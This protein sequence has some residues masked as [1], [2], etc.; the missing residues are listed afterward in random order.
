M[1]RQTLTRLISWLLSLTILGAGLVGFSYK[2]EDREIKIGVLQYVEHNALD[3]A[4]QG[5]V[6][7]LNDSPYGEQI[8]WDIK[9][10]SGDQANL[11]SITNVL[12]REN[13]YLYA[14]ATPAAQSL[15]RAESEK[16]IFFSAVTDPV[17]AGLVESFETPGRN[18]TGTSD[19]QPIADQVDLLVGS[20]PLVKHVGLIYN[21]SEINSTLQAEQASKFLRE[22][23][24]MP[25]IATITS[26]NDIPSVLGSLL[27]KVDAMFMLTDNTIDSSITL[28]GEMTKS[29]GIPMV[30]SSAEVVLENGMLTLSNS[31][32]D[33]GV[34]TADMFIRMLE[35]DLDPS[36]IPVELGRDFELVVNEEYVKAI[37]LDPDQFK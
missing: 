17:D 34:Q 3:A 6:D 19:M 25:E 13:D 27:D 32:Y 28:V 21:S 2:N 9:N 26:A 10:A 35:E 12:V 36:E 30:G 22:K 14:I 7:R 33:Y 31:Y 29:K 20:F 11:Q 4:R 37:G 15:A 18:A 24:I 16:P 8:V 5:F 1:T 23:N